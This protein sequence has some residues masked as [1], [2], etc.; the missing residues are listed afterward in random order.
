MFP[1]KSRHLALWFLIAA[2]LFAAIYFLEQRGN[3]PAAGTPPVLP[4]LRPQTVSVIQIRPA[5]TNQLELRA[6]RTNGQ[7]RLTAPISYPAQSAAIQGLLAFLEHLTPAT[8]ISPAELKSRSRADEE[9]GFVSPQVAT[10]ILQQDDYRFHLQIGR[11]TNPGDQVFLQV[12]GTEGAYVVDAE[13]LNLIPRSASQW[14]DTSLIDLKG[15]AFDKISVTNNAKALVFQRDPATHMW[16]IIWPT[17]ARADSAKIEDALA[18]LQAVHIQQFISDDPK[19]DLESFGL[20]PPKLEI[21]LNQGTNSVAVFYFGRERT[22]GPAT[23]VFGRRPGQNTVFTIKPEPIDPW[24]RASVNDLRDPHLLALSAPVAALDVFAEENFSLQLQTNGTWRISPQDFTADAV[25]AK[26]FLDALLGLEIVQFVKDV[27]PA[28]DLPNYGLANPTRRFV[29]HT[30]L[31]PS[32]ATPATNEILFEVHLGT[33]S[34]DRVF[35]RRTD[36]SAVYAFDAKQLRRFPSFSWQIRDRRVWNI[37]ENDVASATIRQKGR[38]RQIIRKGPHDWALAPGSQGMI[39]DVAVEETVRGLTQ[40]KVQAWVDCGE[41]RRP[42]Y[43]F[44]NVN[45]QITL[46]LKNGD[47]A[48]IEFG[49]ESPSTMPYASVLLSGKDYIFEFPWLLYRDVVNYLSVPPNP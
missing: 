40:M 29:L 12:V 5:G 47:K 8:I 10:V 33:N 34:E 22:N 27:V 25:L 21:A 36:E 35:V 19:A 30:A 48:S 18:R 23:E 26:D 38:I 28:S 43:G 49:D 14:R 15:L 20:Q 39:N 4:A 9:F 42:L 31:N 13:L 44:T 3:K 1:V 32:A 16:R 17:Q 7:W 24:R 45:D 46:E 2:G 6:E 41:A 11:K 37:S